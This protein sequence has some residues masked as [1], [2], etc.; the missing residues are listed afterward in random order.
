[1]LLQETKTVDDAFLSWRS[2]TSISRSTAK[3]LQWR[4]NP[5]KHP[6]DIQAGLLCNAADEQARY[7]EATIAG[8]RFASIYLPMATRRRD[9]N[10]T[11]SWI[12]WRIS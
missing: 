3:K 4:G 7:L 2:R 10:T 9:P 12:G 6:I 8:I 5:L 1:M 11:I